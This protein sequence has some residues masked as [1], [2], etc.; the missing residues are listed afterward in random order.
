MASDTEDNNQN[1]ELLSFN[2]F[3]TNDLFS[4]SNI[5]PDKNFYDDFNISLFQT[6]YFTPNEF[7]KN[8]DM[9]CDSFSVLHLNVRSLNKNFKHFKDFFASLKLKFSVLCFSETWAEEDISKNS[10]FQL[11]GYNLIHQN[12]KDRKGGGLAIF[13]DKIFTFKLR[14][15]LSINSNS[16]ESLTIE[17][18]NKKT[19][20]IILS[21][22]YRPPD[23]DLEAGENYLRDILSKTI[24]TKKTIIFAGDFNLNVLHYD[25]DKKN[26][27]FVILLFEFGMILT[28]NRPTRVC[29]SSATAIDHV[30]TNCV[31]NSEFKSSIIKVDISDHFPI[32]FSFK[33]KEGLDSKNK[34]EYFYKRKFD[35][36][37]INTFKSELKEANWEI[38][39]SYN[40]PNDS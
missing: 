27:N 9:S 26:Q 31:L 30:I 5:D 22:I 28:T 1:F 2:P 24:K 21:A 39:K 36:F 18:F 23:G 19:K 15:D 16:I 33:L 38:L 34:D 37:S 13:V 35:D 10:L 7:T 32:V 4:D 8:F 20:N 25:Q 6:N 29:R 11:E 12:R 17:I 3:A 14:D 40:D